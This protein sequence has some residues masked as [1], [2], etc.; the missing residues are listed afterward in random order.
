MRMI[1]LLVLFAS[2]GVSVVAGQRAT[3]LAGPMVGYATETEVAI[4]FQVSGPAT[5]RV[6]YWHSGRPEERSF[7]RTVTADPDADGC[8]TVKLSELPFGKRFHFELLI[9][10]QPVPRPYAQTFQTQEHWR[11]RRGA[12]SFRVAL[13]S[14]AYHNDPP[15]DRPGRPYGAATTDIYGVMARTQ[16]DL[17]LWLGDNIYLREPD[18]TSRSGINARYRKARENPALQAFLA[19]TS[20]Y[21]IW[22]DHDFGANDSD[23]TNPL[24][25][26]SLALFKRYWPNP[27][28]GLPECAGTFF[29]FTWGDA[30]FFMLDDRYHRSPN[31]APL[32]A[33]KTML[34][35]RQI[36]WLVDSLSSSIATFKVIACGNQVLNVGSR[37][38]KMADFPADRERILKE[39]ARRR[40]SGVF[41]LSGDRHHSEIVTETIYGPSGGRTLHEFTCSP[42][43]SGLHALGDESDNPQRVPGCSFD[44]ERNF[45]LLEFRS[46]QGQREVA[47][48][49]FA[50]DGT[51]AFE[52]VLTEKALL[53]P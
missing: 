45:G 25:E 20:H 23:W 4:W 53:A 51:L 10:E 39:I 44:R 11:W 19:S 24:R 50:A 1:L 16:P 38:E 40:V 33:R 46:A 49:C 35:E 37:H 30:E 41:F 52:H 12:P 34:G 6:A 36:Q 8:V 9:D 43:L 7:S 5:C 18:W 26:D 13:G 29:K 28:A 15:F 27:G 21:A 17:M 2:F 42:L 32:D 47:L 3:L 48:Q 14:C 22:D 31:R